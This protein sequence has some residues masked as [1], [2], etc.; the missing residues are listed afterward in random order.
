MLVYYR[1]PSNVY[2]ERAYSTMYDRQ[3]LMV[4]SSGGEYIYRNGDSLVHHFYDTKTNKFY[5]SNGRIHSTAVLSGELKK[6]NTEQ[7]TY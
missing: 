1:Y 6:F 2:S 3:M 5:L 4:L 7:I